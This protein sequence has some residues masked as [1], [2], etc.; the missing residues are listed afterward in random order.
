MIPGTFGNDCELFFEIELIASDGLELSVNALLD[1]GFSG[2]L[3]M[4]KQDVEELGW[5]YLYQQV[6][7]MAQGK[8][9]I[10]EIYAGKV[11]IGE[12]EVDIPV[13]IGTGVPE[14]LI[15]RQWLKNMRLL[16]DMPLGILTLG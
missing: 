3:A 9:T 12:E 8:D 15:G 1:T 14:F 13:H 6:M 10:F 5:A 16:A 2:W 4:D 11:K 7:R